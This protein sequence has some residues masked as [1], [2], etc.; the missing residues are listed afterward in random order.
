[1]TAKTKTALTAAAFGFAGGVASW[2]VI[3]WWVGSSLA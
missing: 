1:M 3:L 2:L